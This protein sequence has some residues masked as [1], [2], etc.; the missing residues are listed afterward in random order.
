MKPRNMSAVN[1]GKRYR[2]ET[3]SLLASGPSGKEHLGQTS[4]EPEPLLEIRLGGVELGAFFAPRQLGRDGAA[5]VPLPNA[6][7]KLF[8]PAPVL[9]SR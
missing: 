2:T 5:H 9:L 6:Q 8:R 3:A 1:S 7:G 4:A